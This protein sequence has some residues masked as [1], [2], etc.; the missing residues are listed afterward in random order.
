MVPR[1]RLVWLE[2]AET[3]YQALAP[4]ARAEMDRRF[5]E[6][7][8]DPI[9]VRDAI[10][11]RGSDQW[12]IPLAGRKCLVYAVVADPA[13]LTVERVTPLAPA[14]PRLPR[15]LRSWVGRR[16]FWPRS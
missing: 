3:Q 8:H 5:T 11:E 14:R 15:I 6:L 10:Y 7:L 16:W 4:E 2:I 12:S 1:Y 13:T 9:N